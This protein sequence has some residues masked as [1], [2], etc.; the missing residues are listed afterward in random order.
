M[1]MGGFFM[2]R[3]GFLIFVVCMMFLAACASNDSGGQ[4]YTEPPMLIAHGGGGIGIGIDMGRREV[5]EGGGEVERE[6]LKIGITHASH[7]NVGQILHYFG[8]GA[9]FVSLGHEELNNLEQLREFYAIF[10]NC[11]SHVVINP[12]ILQ[13]YVYQGG[14]VYASDLAATPL[15]QAF[16]GMFTYASVSP[17]MTVR[18]AQIPHSTLAS[19]MGVDALDVIFNMGGWN[20]ITQISEGVTTYIQGNVPGHGVSPLAISFE[21]GEGAVF[22]TSFHNNAQAT[23]HMIN[24]IEYLIFRIKFIEADRTMQY[25]AQAHGFDYSGQMF[26]FFADANTSFRAWDVGITASAPLADA[27]EMAMALEADGEAGFGSGT[28]IFRY[29]FAENMDFLLMVDAAG[30]DFTLVL[31]DPRGNIFHASHNGEVYV[32][33][34]NPSPMPNFET[35]AGLG[36]RVSG[37]ASGQWSFAVIADDAHDDATFAIGIATT[38][39]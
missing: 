1:D 18:S 25:L 9:N 5:G 16:P 34:G 13:S 17:D 2:K 30:Q 21:Y 28:G 4:G 22:F 38:T 32:V 36:I 3:F 39:R 8:G 11:G 15:A 12:R 7:D 27:F 37:G 14:I 35:I 20:V 31:N 6:V 19:H 26:G 24:F 10:V 29:T 33:Q 23:N